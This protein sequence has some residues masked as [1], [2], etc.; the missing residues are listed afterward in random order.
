MQTQPSRQRLAVDPGA[1]QRAEN[2]L[3]AYPAISDAEVEEVATYLRSGP[4]MDIALLSSN[5][6]AWSAAERLRIDHKHL[7]ATSLKG[8]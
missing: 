5:E 1:L 6:T 3:H 2:L 8:C 4:Q 7:F